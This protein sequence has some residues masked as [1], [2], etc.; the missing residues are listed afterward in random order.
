MRVI[1]KLA[2][3]GLAI[4]TSI[5]VT[6]VLTAAAP[7]A[8]GFNVLPFVEPAQYRDRSLSARREGLAA[9][10][11]LRAPR[12]LLRSYPYRQGPHYQPPSV[13]YEPP[14]VTYRP[15]RITDRTGC[16]P[17]TRAWYDRCAARYRSFDPSSGTY[18]TYSGQERFCRCP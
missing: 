5:A 16:V 9:T 17:R 11:D 1:T 18:I 3:A 2:A 13:V 8:A 7:G 10:P 14:P 15:P 12:S 6:P 4:A